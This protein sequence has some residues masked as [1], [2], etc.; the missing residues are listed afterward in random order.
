MHYIHQHRDWPNF[1]W[2]TAKLS[3]ELSRVRYEQGLLL[4]RMA[5]LGFD[6]QASAGLENLS[7]DILKSSAI[8]GEI[9]NGEE[10]RSSLGRR[11]GV[12]VGGLTTVS[13]N[14]DGVVEMTLDATQGPA[15]PLSHERLFRWHGLLFSGRFPGITQIAAYRTPDMDPMQV[16][17]G[18][19]GHETV[20]YEAPLA[21]R[22]QK[23]MDTFLAWFN[24]N[25][26]EDPVLKAALAHLWFVTIHPFADGNGRIA[27]AVADCALA[28]GE[29][30]GIRCYSL[31]SQIEK[32]RKAYYDILERTQ[33]GPLDI[34]PWI[35]WFVGCFGRALDSAKG[36]MERV[37]RKA[38]VWEGAAQHTVND[39]QR[40]LLNM[41]L[42]GFEGKL[43]SSKYAKIAGCSHD[44]ALRDI[45]QL[46]SFGILQIEG[47]S[48]R[49]TSYCLSE[50]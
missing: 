49:G 2:D 45:K 25:A 15:R 47:E 19:Y 30:S 8:E 34:T 46:V 50:E 36:V 17:S 39:R 7:Q 26:Q 10:V 29:G 41:L 20:H 44:T 21:A 13:R 38:K 35:L 6:L 42:D 14:V 28:A 23:E 48:R 33:K 16:V 43:T 37:L 27:R 22:L 4:G 32:E 18:Y 1:H 31:S 3:P 24:G 9:L 40:K 11:L 12:D 5:S